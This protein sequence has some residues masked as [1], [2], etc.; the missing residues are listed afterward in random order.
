MTAA[1]K[2]LDRLMPGLTAQERAIIFL[3]DYKDGVTVNPYED[4]VSQAAS[5]EYERLMNIIRFVNGELSDCIMILSGQVAQRELQ[6]GWLEQAC[7]HREDLWI[8]GEYL[9][10]CVPEPVTVSQRKKRKGK[11]PDHGYDVRPDAVKLVGRGGPLEL[12]FDLS[13]AHA[14]AETDTTLDKLRAVAFFIREALASYWTQLASID[15]LVR[16][17]A[18]EFAG[19]DPLK[20]KRRDELD[21]A[22]AQ[23]V[24]T[25]AALQRYV[26]EW[27]L[28]ADHE[29]SLEVTRALAKRVLG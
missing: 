9:N 11:V 10:A 22:I 28:P 8:V 17:Y 18:N 24:A 1:D 14:E 13:G 2:R 20:P 19:E 23:I 16:E 4:A 7:M 27:E 3:R 5:G 12:P 15:V 21:D 29:E 6:L 25:K 26:G